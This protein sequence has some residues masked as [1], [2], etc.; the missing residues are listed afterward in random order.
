MHLRIKMRLRTADQ[1]GETAEGM[2]AFVR[3]ILQVGEG[4]VQ[5]ISI[6]EDGKPNWIKIPQEFLIQN[7]KDGVQN[8]IAAI[9]PNFVTE[10]TNWLYL[11]ERG[12][13]APTNDDVDEI[14]SI[15][16]SMIPGDVKN[17]YEL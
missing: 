1:S 13:L 16:L 8:L 9:Y 10:Y 14:N 6:S 17:L 2:E 4:E 7:D 11:R 12:I 3:W 15:M 5:G